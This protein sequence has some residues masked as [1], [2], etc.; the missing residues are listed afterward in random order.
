MT[1]TNA[2]ATKTKST[3]KKAPNKKGLDKVNLKKNVAAA[4]AEREVKYLY[5]V[6]CK[7]PDQRKEFRRKARSTKRRLEKAIANAPHGDKGKATKELQNFVET[8]LA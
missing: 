6:E 3:T 4:K 8:T 2:S 7:T 1:K 5:P